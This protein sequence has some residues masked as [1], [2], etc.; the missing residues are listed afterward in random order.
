MAIFFTAGSGLD[1]VAAANFVNAGDGRIIKKLTTDTKSPDPV[2]KAY[3]MAELAGVV[4]VL[5]QVL[6]SMKSSGVVKFT[7]S[8]IPLEES[9][10]MVATGAGGLS[11]VLQFYI[12]TIH[13]VRAKIPEYLEAFRFKKVEREPEKAPEVAPTPVQ[14]VSMPSR[15][16]TT[17]VL[18]DAD[19]NIVSAQCVEKDF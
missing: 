3:A 15:V 1:M 18:H 8:W 13:L 5:G 6:T 16:R 14:V 2:V 12:D 7:G 17:D 10:Y 11:H 9:R 19:G 4:E